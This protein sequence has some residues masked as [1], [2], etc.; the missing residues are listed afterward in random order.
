M[1]VGALARRRAGRRR[2]VATA[3]VRFDAATDQLALAAAPTSSATI[4]VTAWVRN[5]ESVGNGTFCRLR[6]AATIASFTA[7][8]GGTNGP[9]LATTGGTAGPHVETGGAL[10]VNAWRRVAFTING[11][12][13]GNCVVYWGDDNPA[14]SALTN[15]GSVATGAPTALAVGGRGGGDTTERWG[16]DIAYMRTWEAV[17]TQAQIQT[18]WASRTPVVTTNL[19]A[20]WTLQGATDLADHSGNARNLSAG[21]TA[22]T[23]VAGPLI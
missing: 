4:T 13:A 17:L 22:V 12:G 14:S 15:T 19:W 18:E 11:T 3:A 9:Q 1:S 6:A 20:D 10:P 5:I 16:G 2:S 21:S 8:S 7:S 23:T